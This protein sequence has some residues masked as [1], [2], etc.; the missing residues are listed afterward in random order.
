MSLLADC[1]TQDLFLVS[2]MSFFSM[3]TFIV[4]TGQPL[5]ATSQILT[6]DTCTLVHVHNVT[7]GITNLNNVIL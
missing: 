4:E 1:V 5:P 6:K 3:N 2:I 7:L